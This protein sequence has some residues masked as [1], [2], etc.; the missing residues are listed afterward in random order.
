MASFIGKRSGQANTDLAQP[1]IGA[2]RDMLRHCMATEAWHPATEGV[3]MDITTVLSS[4]ADRVVRQPDMLMRGMAYDLDNM[5]AV[6][7][8]G[9][10]SIERGPNPQQLAR[11]VSGMKHA[12][13]N[14][15]ALA[16]DIADLSARSGVTTNRVSVEAVIQDMEPRV[17][18]ILG[19]SVDFR[20]EIARDLWPVRVL[21]NYLQFALFNLLANAA[22][23]MPKGG[24]LVLRAFNT[25]R[26]TASPIGAA[27][28]FVRLEMIDS[29]EG[30]APDVLTR[31]FEPFFT[32]RQSLKR[33]GLGLGQVRRF[34]TQFGGD[35]AVESDPG[36]GTRVILH[37]PR[38]ARGRF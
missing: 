5:L 23:A 3:V 18:E 25:F 22:D 37:L 35:I 27:G 30:I 34:A 24:V 33:T 19:E 31:V 10:V 14:A 28:D 26:S 21:P 17:R 6:I 8:S 11:I 16:D 13:R 36:A 15:A 2:G 4:P 9:L 12:I 38:A 1:Q 32:T 20:T 29:G 7:A